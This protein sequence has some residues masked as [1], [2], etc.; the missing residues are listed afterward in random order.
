MLGKNHG[1]H[2]SNLQPPTPHSI[3]ILQGPKRHFHQVYLVKPVRSGNVAC[4]HQQHCTP[5]VE[6]GYRTMTMAFLYILQ[7]KYLLH[8]KK[9]PQAK[10]QR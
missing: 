3:R 6:A 1:F 4:I 10:Y 8:A 2:L 5:G 9:E 7:G